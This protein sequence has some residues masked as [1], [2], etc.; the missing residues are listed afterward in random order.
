MTNR[1]SRGV[2]SFVTACVLLVL[3]AIAAEIGLRIKDD[4]KTAT[5]SPVELAERLTVPCWRTVRTLRP[6]AERETLDPDR[7]VRITVRINSLGLRGEEPQIP[8]SPGT[9]RILL[10]GDET[11]FGPY[12]AEADTVAARL[13][14]LLGSRTDLQVEVVNAAVP[15]DCPLLS[16]L[17]VKGTLLSLDPDLIVQHFDISDIAESAEYRRRTRLDEAGRA[18][19]CPSATLESGRHLLWFEEL[20]LTAAATS[21]LSRFFEPPATD[22]EPN[23]SMGLSWPDD[24]AQGELIRL[25][26][27]LAPLTELRQIADGTYSKFLVSTCPQPW[28]VSPTAS[29]GPS[30]R[31]AAGV[32]AGQHYLSRSVFDRVAAYTTEHSIAWCDAVPY[33]EDYSA[34]DVLF[35][36]NSVGLSPRGAE[37]YAR[38]LA[39]RI[40][41]ETPYVWRKVSGPGE[42]IPR[43]ADRRAETH[44]HDGTWFE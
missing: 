38:V 40:M 2:R 28:Q 29:S 15:G 1:L 44:S 3:T 12:L 42:N 34:P 19:A 13:E 43:A 23:R 6:L 26:Q 36:K 35:F 4:Y 22:A 17:R 5:A 41:E 8:K 37:L 20:K 14:S 25:E 7:G 33:F 30:V 39:K 31:E 18:L 21:M 11:F 10:L 32:Q 27:A 16:T 9:F 24:P